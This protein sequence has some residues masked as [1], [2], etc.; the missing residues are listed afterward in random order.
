MGGFFGCV[1][2]EATTK[3]ALK[4]YTA[5]AP[6]RGLSSERTT[7]AKIYWLFFLALLAILLL[8]ALLLINKIKYKLIST[9]TFRYLHGFGPA[10]AELKLSG[11]S[12]KGR[13]PQFA[14]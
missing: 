1:L 14:N 7:W 2:A 12:P 3:N 6:I 8:L 13:R 5:G 9:L 11:Y 4:R 10:F